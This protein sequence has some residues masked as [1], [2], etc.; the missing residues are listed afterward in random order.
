MDS[1]TTR[2]LSAA[3]LAALA[4]G[5]AP[6]QTIRYSLDGLPHAARSTG[7][8]LGVA[9]VEDA[10]R[11]VPENRAVFQFERSF[12]ATGRTFCANSERQYDPRTPVARAVSL[13]I[14]E[15]L[16]RRGGFRDVVL[17]PAPAD[18]VLS[19]SLRQLYGVQERSAG[20]GVA[21]GAGAAFGAIGG[22]VGALVSAS[23]ETD[24]LVR[25]ELTD[26]ALRRADG[27]IVARLD[28]VIVAYAGKLPADSACL[29]IYGAVNARLRDAV[30]L[31]SARVEGAIPAE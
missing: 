7:A 3:A 30:E 31:L 29:R 10:R 13:R 9:L 5:C 17:S 21:A 14:R 4:A 6:R 26:L 19:G 12:E 20:A 27:S 11:A 18:F 22:L 2:W 23:F 8:V 1:N 16:A 24:G 28:P 15:H 25:I